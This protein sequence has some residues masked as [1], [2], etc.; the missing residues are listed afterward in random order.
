MKQMSVLKSKCMF[1]NE[2]F[3]GEHKCAPL[4]AGARMVPT[5]KEE[6]DQVDEEF[7]NFMRLRYERTLE[8]VGI[9]FPQGKLE[10]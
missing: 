6:Q 7:S 8:N 4:N 3:E 10:E 1:C 9:E 2:E 5:T